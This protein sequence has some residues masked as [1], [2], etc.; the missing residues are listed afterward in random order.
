MEENIRIEL[1]DWLFNAGVTGLINILGEE[2]V[3]Y[4]DNQTVEIP[5]KLFENFEEK[6]FNYFIDKYQRLLSWNKIVSYEE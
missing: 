5:A 1:G 3:N 2:N 6:Y 4:T